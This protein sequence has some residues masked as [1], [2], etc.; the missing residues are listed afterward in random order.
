MG[1][2]WL[3]W[4]LIAA[5]TLSN[6]LLLKL[7]PH[8]LRSQFHGLLIG[9]VILALSIFPQ[10]VNWRIDYTVTTGQLL[11]D[12]VLR[13]MIVQGH[14]PIGLYSHRGHA[15]FVL[16]AIATLVI[17]GWKWR[18]LS[19][20]LM[21]VIL[22]P[23]LT[24]LLLT[25]TR[26]GI[27]AILIASM[28]L[29]GRKHYR[30]LILATLVCLLTVGIATSTRQIAA[31]HNYDLSPQQVLIKTLTS[32]REYLWSQSW[33][34]IVRRPL[35]GWGSD[36]FGVAY[37]YIVDRHYTPQV[38]RLGHLSYDYVSKDGQRLTRLMLTNKAHNLFLDTILSVGVLGLLAYTALI[39]FYFWQ[40]IK[41]PYRGIE[42]V[43]IV[44]LAFT[45]TW[46]ECAQYTHIAWWAL[47]L[48]GVNYQ[49]QIAQQLDSLLSNSGAK[50]QL[51][52][53]VRSANI[54]LERETLAQGTKT[55]F[56]IATFASLLLLFAGGIYWVASVDS[57]YFKPFSLIESFIAFGSPSTC[58]SPR[59][60]PE[61]NPIAQR[62]GSS[63]IPV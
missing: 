53:P 36:G 16:A 18:W 41:S 63:T 57:I 61:D 19:L 15:A 14:Q 3:Y 30:V 7:H 28:Y 45:L 2:G 58:G 34:G 52:L 32:D 13:S 47:S 55:P 25:Q 26:M 56:V 54:N 21:T 29:L 62:Y 40:C 5:F 11:Q 12:N 22:L 9:G 43:A 37:P 33:R 38:L 17:V 8:L 23:I 49:R 50:T 35:L 4:L 27:L 48:G 6:A 60:G 10:V 20:Q 44:Y 42:A 51:N 24:A 39:G 1:D 31:L 59:G 46:F